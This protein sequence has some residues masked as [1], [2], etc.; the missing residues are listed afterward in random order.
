MF[1]ILQMEILRSDDPKPK[2]MFVLLLSAAFLFYAAVDA[3]AGYDRQMHLENSEMEAFVVLQSEVALS[4]LHIIYSVA[5]ISYTIVAYRANDGFTTRRIPFFAFS[6]G[7]T[8]LVLLFSDV[9][10]LYTGFWMYTVKPILFVY[11]GVG[12][13]AALTLYLLHTGGS[14]EYFGLDKVK[15]T[16]HVIELAQKSDDIDDVGGVG[17]EE[18]E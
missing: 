10:C 17:N 3:T 1:L 6:A 16:A 7:F 4:F 13:L 15:D 8:V 2:R 12:T 9:I 5:L 18:E 11:S 14:P